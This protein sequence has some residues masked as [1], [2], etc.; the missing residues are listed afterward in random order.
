M[1]KVRLVTGFVPIPDH[2]RS[3]GEY[4]RLAKGF[5]EIGAEPL[6][7]KTPLKYCWLQDWFDHRSDRGEHTFMVSRGDNPAKNT[8]A[9]HVVQHQKTEWLRQATFDDGDAET[10]IWID[11]GIF[12]QPGVTAAVISDFLKRIRPKDFAIPGCWPV[13]YNPNGARDP[14]WRFCG[15][16]AVVPRIYVGEFNAAV[17][18][19]TKARVRMLNHLTWEVNDWADVEGLKSLPIRWYAADHNQTQ[20]TN[21]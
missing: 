7:Y 14:N 4:H 10:F 6:V 19:I 8:T 18:M 12:H 13:G 2:P 17:K 1:T 15:S 5:E 16:V 3:E 21:Y 9:Y 20:F 11:Y